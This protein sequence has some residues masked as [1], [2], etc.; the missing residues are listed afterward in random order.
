MA[1][2]CSARAAL[3]T[4]LTLDHGSCFSR[5]LAGREKVTEAWWPSGTVTFDG[6]F[7]DKLRKRRAIAK[8]AAS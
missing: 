8:A 2:K 6:S 3:V 1:R 5:F 7:S 4:C